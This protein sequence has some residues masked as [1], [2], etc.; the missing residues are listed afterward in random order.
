MSEILGP[1]EYGK[2]RRILREEALKTLELAQ[3]LVIEQ[4]ILISVDSGNTMLFEGM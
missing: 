3:T 1:I 4:S 2:F